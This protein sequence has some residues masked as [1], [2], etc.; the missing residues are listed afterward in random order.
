MPGSGAPGLGWI[1]VREAPEDALQRV[2]GGPPSLDPGEAEAIALALNTRATAVVDDL[3]GRVRARKLGVALTGT[4][5]EVIALHR[6]G[7]GHRELEADIELLREA[8][9][10][11][12][13]DLKRRVLEQFRAE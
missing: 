9:M 12:S 3:R 4:L 2:T 11:L 5:G 6:L 8:G 10:H 1:E 13:N 7:R